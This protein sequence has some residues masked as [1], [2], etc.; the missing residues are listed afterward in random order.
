MENKTVSTLLKIAMVSTLFSLF[1]AFGF[2]H[3]VAENSD[4][5][6]YDTIGWNLAN[7]N[8]FSFSH[9]LPYEPTMFREPAYPVF[10]AIIYKVF[11][12]NIAFVQIFQMIIFS[13]TCLLIY[14]LALNIFDKKIAKYAAF[15]TALCP[16]LANYPSYILSETL[17]TFILCL[18]I[19][20]LTLAVKLKKNVLF[21]VSGILVGA[22]ALCKTV[23]LLFIFPVLIGIIIL[24]RDKLNFLKKTIIYCAFFILPF[25]IIVSMWSFR[26]HAVCG[27]YKI[28][29]RGGLEIW[30]MSQKLDNSVKEIKYDI[31]YNFSEFLGNKLFPE[32]AENPRDVIL[33][34]TK[35][36]M[37]KEDE[38]RR[39]GLTPANIDKKMLEEAIPKIFKKP[40]KYL[41][42]I[43]IESIK[44]T[45]FIYVP[46]LNESYVIEKFNG[47]KK[48]PLILSSIR[49]IF[50]FSAYPFLAL[51]L[52][53]MFFASRSWRNWYFIVGV[54]IY[55]NLIYSMLFAM[56]R[57]AVP[58]IP[59]YSIFA[60]IGLLKLLG[61]E[62][63]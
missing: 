42:Y 43:F 10:L 53:G 13:L 5:G 17:F 28:S 26:N 38:L 63:C 18:S 52:V 35:K 19:L 16:T 54:I 20:S 8:G 62:G 22:A 33:S 24:N 31:A 47:L 2:N 32:A 29:L 27:T 50:R 14:V 49:G 21:A 1:F 44:M 15:A 45:A 58:L 57:Y 51:A 36:S 12:H 55:I 9:S 37:E 3:P 41:S 4:A 46:I 11:G 40:V 6:Q 59:F 34:G 61:K 60:S 25:L 30:Q 56:G 39:Q 23:M 48:G 7:G